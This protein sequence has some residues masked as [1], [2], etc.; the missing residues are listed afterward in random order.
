MTGLCPHGDCPSSAAAGYGIRLP[1][2]GLE[3]TS[4]PPPTSAMSDLFGSFMIYFV[5]H[6]PSFA[7]SFAHASKKQGGSIPSALGAPPSDTRFTPPSPLLV[8][9]GFVRVWTPLPSPRPSR[10]R[11]L[12][13]RWP[14][15]FALLGLLVR[16]IP[17]RLPPLLAR[18]IFDARSGFILRSLRLCLPSV[19]R[20]PRLFIQRLPRVLVF[21][22]GR[23]AV[24]LRPHPPPVFRV[25]TSPRLGAIRRLWRMVTPRRIR[26]LPMSLTFI[27]M[28]PQTKL[29]RLKNDLSP[30]FG[31]VGLEATELLF[32]YLGDTYKP[33][34]S[35]TAGEAPTS[36]SDSGF[37]RP[38]SLPRSGITVLSD[39]LSEFVRIAALPSLKSAPA[40]LSLLFRL[41]TLRLGHFLFLKLIFR[42]SWLLPTNVLLETR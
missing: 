7:T 39:F 24:F 28:I 16:V 35:L 9:K 19:Y 41:P 11:G 8:G 21:A 3:S 15:A 17:L 29:L 31:N 32:K 6:N 23:L 27:R 2:P 33:A 5:S 26:F 12:W 30:D 18:R 22:A 38:S 1:G 36:A 37:F 14:R 42:S 34:F 20:L 25:R 4:T 40:A 10:G 13:V